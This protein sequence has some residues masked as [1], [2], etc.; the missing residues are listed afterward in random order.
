ME[1][2]KCFCPFCNADITGF[3]HKQVIV[4]NRRRYALAARR[5]ITKKSREEITRASQ[6]RLRKWQIEHPEETRRKAA[7]ASRTRTAD[8]F[9]RQARTI[10]ETLQRKSVKF[11][12]LLYE[13]RSKGQ[14]ITPDIEVELMERAR[15]IVKEENRVQRI[16]RKK[17]A[18]KKKK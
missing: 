11:A 15:Q 3:M 10:R 8:S 7:A 13:A 9:A 2:G 4:Y 12:E 18:A 16:A 14:E 6:A 5:K 17:A 1:K